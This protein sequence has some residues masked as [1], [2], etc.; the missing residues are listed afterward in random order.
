MVEIQT[1]TTNTKHN[2]NKRFHITD[3]FT[4]EDRQAYF[5]EQLEKEYGLNKN[6]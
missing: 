4:D 1:T 2:K 6:E 3:N 5:Q